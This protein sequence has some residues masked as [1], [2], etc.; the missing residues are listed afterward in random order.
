MAIDPPPTDPSSTVIDG[1][2]SK[3]ASH[4]SAIYAK[5]YPDISKI[6]V[7]DGQNFKPWQERISSLLDMH[8][9]AWVLNEPK[10][11]SVTDQ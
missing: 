6:L 4:S 2:L 1:V 11:K 10:P 7:I 3:Q 5:P 9:V 8:I